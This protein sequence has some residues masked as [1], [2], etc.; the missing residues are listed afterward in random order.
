M[1]AAP[2]LS[3]R[4]TGSAVLPFI[5]LGDARTGSNM[6]VDALNSHPRIVCF[7]EVMNFVQEFVDY[8]VAGY[9]QQDRADFALRKDD[10]A[11]FLRERIFGGHAAETAA[12]G[13]KLHYYHIWGFDP[14]Y[15]GLFERVLEPLVGDNELRVVHLQ[16][17]NQLRSLVS[18]RL[19][20]A[21]GVWIEGQPGGQRAPLA[22]SATQRLLDRVRGAASASGKR[23]L[24]SPTSIAITPEDCLSHF[25]RLASEITRFDG[26]FAGH[27][28]L[29]VF[30]EDLVASQRSLD[31]VQ[32]FLGVPPRPLTVALRRQNPHP[33]PELIANFDELRAAFANSPQRAF[34]EDGKAG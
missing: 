15:E 25:E 16:R 7:R 33:L 26:L 30:Y 27:E 32:R 34:F 12:A 13:F 3:E 22:R 10:P 5:V 14:Q 11:R 1:T 19:A 4:H 20:Q 21:T 28:M 2:K 23:P 18:L 8:G 6:L 9:D 17:R 31:D 29:T 24:A